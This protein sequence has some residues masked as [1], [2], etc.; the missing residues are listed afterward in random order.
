MSVIG[1]VCK[2]AFARAHGI[3]GY[4]EAIMDWDNKTTR[5]EDK[6]QRTHGHEVN[7]GHRD[8]FQR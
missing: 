5:Q 6:L 4:F 8:A 7:E 2:K 3:N 1:D